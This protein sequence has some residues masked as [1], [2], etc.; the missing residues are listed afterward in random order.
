MLL[1]LHLKSDDFWKRKILFLASA[2]ENLF[3]FSC[4]ILLNFFSCT[5]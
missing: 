5:F 2:K 4:T 1:D 3:I